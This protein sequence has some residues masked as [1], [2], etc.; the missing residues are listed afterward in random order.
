MVMSKKQMGLA[1]LCLG[2]G[3]WVRRKVTN[4]A[5]ELQTLKIQNRPQFSA[6]ARSGD[7]P[8]VGSFGVD[9]TLYARL[10]CRVRTELNLGAVW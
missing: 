4:A 5:T 1:I 9:R 7:D 2:G 8:T 6:G 10:P 3:W